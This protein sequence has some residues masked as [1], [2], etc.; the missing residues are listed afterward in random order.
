MDNAPS[1]ASSINMSDGRLEIE[2]RW[3]LKVARMAGDWNEPLY[4]C[5]QYFVSMCPIQTIVSE[6]GV[7]NLLCCQ[8]RSR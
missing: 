3:E 7:K 6:S 1:G 4:T 5:Q 8:Y 2:A